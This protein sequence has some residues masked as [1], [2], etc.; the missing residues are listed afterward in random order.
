VA[1]EKAVQAQNPPPGYYIGEIKVNDPDAMKPYREGVAAT[2]EKYGGKFIVRGGKVDPV[3]GSPPNGVVAIIAFRSLADAKRW[4][5]SPEYRAII[6][7]RHK[8]ATSRVFLVEG[9]P[10]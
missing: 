6:D 10:N 9:L 3:E 5:E 7:V 1:A 4:Y 8:A 2:V